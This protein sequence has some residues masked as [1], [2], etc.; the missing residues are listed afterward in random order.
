MSKV[1]HPPFGRPS[2]PTTVG[3]RRITL[4]N[5]DV[6]GSREP[7]AASAHLEPA[8]HRTSKGFYMHFVV[9]YPH[10]LIQHGVYFWTVPALSE[11]HQSRYVTPC[12]SYRALAVS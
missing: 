3:L 10:T 6:R 11:I 8:L 12:L 9:L 5:A 4:Q 7:K 2:P 1:N